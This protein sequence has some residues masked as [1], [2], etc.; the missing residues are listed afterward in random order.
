MG[1]TTGLLSHQDF[2]DF[3]GAVVWQFFTLGDLGV[4]HRRRETTRDMHDIA[5]YPHV[6][7][8]CAPELNKVG[9]GIC[10]LT[11]CS[12]AHSIQAYCAGGRACVN[13]YLCCT[14][15]QG[16]RWPSLT[17]HAM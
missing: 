4:L 16:K 13:A 3:W 10:I 12:L 2:G 5:L 14:S 17:P 8:I 11:V 7:L 9:S 6:I 1:H 15:V